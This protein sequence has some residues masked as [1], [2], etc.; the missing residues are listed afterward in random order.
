MSLKK[1]IL[2]PLIILFLAAFAQAKSQDTTLNVDKV[3]VLSIDSTINPA[4]LNYL[5]TGF[6][7]A[8]KEGFSLINVEINTPGGLVTTTKDILTLFG[9]SDIPIV[10]WVKPE[11]A[12]ATSAGAIIASGAHLLFM[13]DG[14]NI[15]A[16]TPVQGGGDIKSKD[17]RNKAINDLVAL[18][19][20]L[21][22][23]KGRN[24][25]L[26]GDMIKKASSF[27]AGEAKI[28]NLADEIVNSRREFAE[29]LD[30][31]VIKIKGETFKLAASSS[32][33]WKEHAWDGGQELLNIFADPSMAYILFLIGCALIYLELQAPGGFI[34]GSIGAICLVLAAI[35][36]QVL[37]LNIGALG[38]IIL[39]FILFVIEIY[40]TSYGILS[41][42]GLVS[43]IF[44]SMFLYRTENSYLTL[45]TSLIVSTVAGIG[46]FIA[47]IAWFLMRDHKNIGT[48]HF[49]DLSGKQAKVIEQQDS[50][51]V[52]KFT[53]S[54]KVGAEFWKAVSER[55]LTIDEQYEIKTQDHE[56]MLLII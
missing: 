33:E 4:T 42:A 30:G 11:G 13:S 15:G 49:N 10:V 26:F 6:D 9:N 41:V 14:T 22:E 25:K 23:S 35:G 47:F 39:S 20:S 36:F 34:A 53:Y 54:V 52:G 48:G 55:E 5:K 16:A 44:G 31:K 24:P 19:Q 17:L 27:K 8:S 51:E 29:K 1:L 56:R 50:E 43:L 38:L 46:V 7:R 2:L 40:I 32:I 21:S 12:S 37:P 3:L 18:V 45:S 28:K